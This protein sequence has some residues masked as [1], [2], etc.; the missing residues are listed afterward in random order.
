MKIGSAVYDGGP[1]ATTAERVEVD[2][3]L[4]AL[5]VI[6]SGMTRSGD[7]GPLLLPF[8][9]LIPPDA[10]QALDRTGSPRPS[11]SPAAAAGAIPQISGK[12]YQYREA[13]ILV[14]VAIAE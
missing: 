9:V 5:E 1:A 11:P 13:G 10:I 6:R 14:V 4:S 12:S 2:P 3:T 8:F 7:S